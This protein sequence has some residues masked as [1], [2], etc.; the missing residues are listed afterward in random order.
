MSD[1]KIP[2]QLPKFVSIA[3]I[4]YYCRIVD[5]ELEHKRHEAAFNLCNFQNDSLSN[6]VIEKNLI[7]S[8]DYAE[9]LKAMQKKK[10]YHKERLEMTSKEHA[11]AVKIFEDTQAMPPPEPKVTVLEPKKKSPKQLMLRDRLIDLTLDPAEEEEEKSE[12]EHTS[13]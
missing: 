2:A 12:L 6:F 4:N 1:P 8:R 3:A 9:S 11:D 10:E 5:I 7:N 13:V